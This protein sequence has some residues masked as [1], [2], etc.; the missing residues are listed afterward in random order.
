MSRMTPAHAL[1]LATQV[2]EDL[3]F[4]AAMYVDA[5]DR[6]PADHLDALARAGLYGIA[7]P[8]ATGLGADATTLSTVIEIMSGGCL[9]T[10][11]VWIQ[12]HSA[13][14]AVA[15][16]E[17][18]GLRHQW[19]EPLCLGAQRAG[20]ALGGARPGPPL[21]R[22]R[23]VPGG[24]VLDGSAPWVTGWDMIDVIYTLA[25]DDAGNIVAALLPAQVGATLAA[26][27]LPLVAVN[28]SRT[29]VLTFTGH[30]VPA[31]LITDVMPYAQ[32][33]ARDASGLRPNGSLSLGIG[34]RCCR[35]LGELARDDERFAANASQLAAE[36]AVR[37]AALDDADPAAMPGARAAASA[38]AFQAA[39]VLVAAAGSHAIVAGE[40]PQ[41]LAREAL[42]LLVFGSR[43]AIK[44]QLATLLIARGI[45]D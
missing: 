21:L 2:A 5:A 1:S 13:V 34:S 44:E 11:F 41:R 35:L 27:G 15:A 26:T 10:T 8:A 4:P 12:H 40:H 42:F 18:A 20:I 36:L 23:P 22:A 39:G 14:R 9:A 30:F 16:S 28:A 6:I 37:R 38:F 17:N 3:L 29:V 25:R 33:L 19:L 31:D 7:G 45:G 43:P 24:Y 32:W